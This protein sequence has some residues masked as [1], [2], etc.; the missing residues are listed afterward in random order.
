ME[1][2]EYAHLH[3]V[4]RQFRTWQRY[5]THTNTRSSNALSLYCVQLQTQYRNRSVKRTFATEARAYRCSARS[6]RETTIAQSIL[7]RNIQLLR[8]W[9]SEMYYKRRPGEDAYR[10]K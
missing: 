9:I 4:Q 3:R 5:H 1:N 8:S 2:D 6:S 10:M 7:L